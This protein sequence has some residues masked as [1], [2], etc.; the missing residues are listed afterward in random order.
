MTRDELRESVA[1]LTPVERQ[2]AVMLREIYLRRGAEPM[3]AGH[4]AQAE[5][6][7][8]YR[9]FIGLSQIHHLAM[10]NSARP[11]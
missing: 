7:W 11:L 6:F 8:K 9:D 3:W 1:S 5:R 4:I 2:M 10:D